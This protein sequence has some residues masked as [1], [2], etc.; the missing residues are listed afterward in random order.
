MS[1]WS[2]DVAGEPW[3]KAVLQALLEVAFKEVSLPQFML[4]VELVF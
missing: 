1:E 3:R 4:S 2:C